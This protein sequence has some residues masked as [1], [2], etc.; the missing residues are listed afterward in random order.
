MNKT[1]KKLV[2]HD[3]MLLLFYLFICFLYLYPK[4]LIKGML[5]FLHE[6]PFF[7]SKFFLV[8]F[9][10]NF[11][12]SRWFFNVSEYYVRLVKTRFHQNSLTIYFRVLNFSYKTYL[13]K[14][15]IFLNFVFFKIIIFE[16]LKHKRVNF[17]F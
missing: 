13:N 12:F 16:I 6:Y 9:S 14:Y 7:S 11:Q 2:L 17:M 8:K 3:Y 15:T 1:I 5:N 10:S 4:C